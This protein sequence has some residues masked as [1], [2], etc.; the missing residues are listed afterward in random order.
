[1]T[2]VLQWIDT[3]GASDAKRGAEIGK[4][5][6][7]TDIKDSA[8]AKGE[9]C[10]GFKIDTLGILKIANA[11]HK[12]MVYRNDMGESV[13]A[14]TR[15][16]GFLFWRPDPHTGK[17]VRADTQAW[18]QN[19]DGS[20]KFP[21]GSHRMRDSWHKDRD[22]W[23]DP[24]G[25]PV[26]EDW[27]KS[28]SC[29]EVNKMGEP[30]DAAFFDSVIV[31]DQFTKDHE[32]LIGGKRLKVDVIDLDVGQTE[33]F[34]ALYI[35]G[36]LQTPRERRQGRRD[37]WQKVLKE[38]HEKKGKR[39]D[40]STP[41]KMPVQKASKMDFATKD[42]NKAWNE[43]MDEDL[44]EKTVQEIFDLLLPGCGT[45]AA[46][47]MKKLPPSKLKKDCSSVPWCFIYA[48][49]VSLVIVFV[50]SVVSVVFK[51]KKNTT[52]DNTTQQV[53]L[54]FPVILRSC[55]FYCLAVC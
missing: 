14:G 18:C 8:K 21:L 55:S 53:L 7:I 3:D 42:L 46:R 44:K 27:S 40:G 43:G 31:P 49:V 12:G 29:K 4:Q 19:R 6:M 41:A 9:E 10:K 23:L 5:E 51:I 11:A 47:K 25:K 32:I 24:D 36:I 15:R 26:P 17:L 54:P 30:E 16:N 50:D 45:N 28:N 39:K 37:Q 52:Q 13:L 2:P 1:M 35:E 33:I 22:S 38:L 20:V 48:V 34:N